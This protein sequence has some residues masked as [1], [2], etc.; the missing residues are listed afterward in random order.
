[1]NAAT[2]VSTHAVI[3]DR[4]RRPTA[5]AGGGLFTLGIEPHGS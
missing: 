5:D 2:E 3:N 4:E 1:V